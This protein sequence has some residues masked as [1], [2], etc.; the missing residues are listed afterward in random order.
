MKK[1]VVV[2]ATGAI[3]EH[4]VGQL[5]S[6]GRWNVTTV[7][8]RPMTVPPEYKDTAKGELKQVNIN[9]DKLAAEAGAEFQGADSVFCC[10]GT[11]RKAAG[12]A[13][14]FIKVDYEYVK[15]SAEAAKAAGCSHFSLVTAQGSNA[16]LWANNWGM[17]HMLLYPQTKGRAE[18]AVKQQG[19]ASALIYRPGLLNRGDKSRGIEKMMLRLSDGIPVAGVAKLMIAGAEEPNRPTVATYEMSEMLRALKEGRACRA[20][21]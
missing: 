10:L 14:D 21:K 12:S 17:F 15:A 1:A 8:R 13:E 5:L 2:G 7:G 19:F 4:V 3:G 16:N 18:E 20:S 9:M 6:S 11:T